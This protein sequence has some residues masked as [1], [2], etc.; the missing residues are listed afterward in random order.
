M[1]KH[2]ILI[3]YSYPITL[4]PDHHFMWTVLYVYVY[5]HLN[6]LWPHDDILKS[7][8]WDK[9]NKIWFSEVFTICH[10]I[11]W[12]PLSQVFRKRN[13]C[14]C[15]D[16]N[17]ASVLLFSKASKNNWHFKRIGQK[18]QRTQKSLCERWL[19]LKLTNIYKIILK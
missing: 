14:L 2:S 18:I 11:N 5:I 4:K 19:W 9:T 3:L 17:E 10:I 12:T 16:N 1:W 6:S 8:S 13:C 7:K 15:H